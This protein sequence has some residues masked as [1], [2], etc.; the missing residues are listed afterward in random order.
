MK[1]LA[2]KL[3][4]RDIVQ[5][6]GSVVRTD[7]G[8]LVVRAGSGHYEARRAASCL[9]EPQ[10]GDVVLIAV[11]PSGLCYVLAVL[12]REQG[13]AA[14]VAL[15]GDLE[16]K[17]A[18]G[19]LRV[20][21]QEGVDVASAKEISLLSGGLRVHASEGSV[22]VQRL[23]ML[24]GLIQAEVEKVKVLAGSIDSVLDRISQRVKRAYRTVEE[25]DQLRAERV[26]YVA[27]KSMRL[28]GENTVMTAEELVKIDGEQIHLG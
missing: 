19:R 12:D 22:V 18:R 26:D 8:A 14:R 7:G 25:M 6:T 11:L 4:Q 16:I 24:G 3:D 5:E 20:A 9:L 28:H 2:R 15:E 10:P 23:S 27:K 21:A 13:A 1:N 17:L